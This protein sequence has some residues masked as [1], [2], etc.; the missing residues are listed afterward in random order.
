MHTVLCRPAR[1]KEAPTIAEFQ[2]RMAAETEDLVLDWETVTQGVQAVFED[3]AKGTYW[4]AE[5]DGQ[6]V[7]SLLITP[8]WSDWRNATVWWI[9]SVYV[10]PESRGQGVYRSLYLTIKTEVEKAHNLSGL[11]LYVDKRNAN[12][13]KTYEALGMSGDH[14]LLYEW[15][16]G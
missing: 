14:Y 15:L 13:Q 11:R 3:R 9:Q 6:V 16:K 7:A 5:K 4:V 8:E 12:A 1:V 2:I 10:V